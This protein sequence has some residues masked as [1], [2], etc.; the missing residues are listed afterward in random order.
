MFSKPRKPGYNNRGKEIEFQYEMNVNQNNIMAMLGNLQY[1][2]NK[3]ITLL[4]MA[5]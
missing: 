3:Q 5:K 1:S 2:K 4:Y